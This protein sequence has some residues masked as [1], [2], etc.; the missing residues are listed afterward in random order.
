MLRNALLSV[1]TAAV[2]A[3]VIVMVSRGGEVEQIYKY[4][5]IRDDEFECESRLTK[6]AMSG[7]ELV[8][9]TRDA[10]GQCTMYLRINRKFLP[11]D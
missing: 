9:V 4:S 5:V 7:W 8:T 3:G 2:T 10:P 11:N 1:A 6:A